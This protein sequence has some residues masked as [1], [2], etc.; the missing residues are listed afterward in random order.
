MNSDED[1]VRPARRPARFQ[2]SENTLFNAG[3]DR[4]TVEAFRHLLNKVGDSSDTPS[5]PATAI[6]IDALEIAP[7]PQPQLL[8]DEYLIPPLQIVEQIEFL[9]TE[10]RQLSELL[11]VLSG[12]MNDIEQGLKP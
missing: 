12:K 8:T 9:Q 3:M 4:P 5:I 11:A 2:I 6:S 10:V 1:F 7:A